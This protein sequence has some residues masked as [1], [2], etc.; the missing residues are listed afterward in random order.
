MCVPLCRLAALVLHQNLNI[1]NINVLLQKMSR[2]T[3][4]NVE[5]SLQN[6]H[7]APYPTSHGK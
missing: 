1:P 3:G 4:I 2:K 6:E 7:R 5:R